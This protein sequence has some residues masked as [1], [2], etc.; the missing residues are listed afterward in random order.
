ML[1]LRTQ[2]QKVNMFSS[3]IPNLTTAFLLVESA[4]KCWATK[5]SSLACCELGQMI[6]KKGQEG[7]QG[8]EKWKRPRGRS[9][10]RAQG[11]AGMGYG[12]MHLNA[13][14][15]MYTTT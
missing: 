14:V 11:T 8:S 2:S 13:P 1:P 9:K 15:K 5:A 7:K 10:E 4:T 3:A 12:Y 6:E